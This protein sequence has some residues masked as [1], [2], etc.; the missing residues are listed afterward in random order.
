MVPWCRDPGAAA[1]ARSPHHHP[2]EAAE[3]ARH[4][5]ALSFS[6]PQ[7]LTR[8]PRQ[9][10]AAHLVGS[11]R[12][13]VH[14]IPPPSCL[15]LCRNSRSLSPF[16]VCFARRSQARLYAVRGADRRL[17]GLRPRPRVRISSPP[18][19]PP[20]PH[21]VVPDMHP[22]ARATPACS[23]SPTR[24]YSYWGILARM[25]IARYSTKVEC[26][27]CARQLQGG[28]DAAFTPAD[29]HDRRRAA[30]AK[31]HLVVGFTDWSANQ[32]CCC[33]VE[34]SHTPCHAGR[35]GEG[36]PQEAHHEARTRRH[37]AVCALCC[38]RAH[39][40]YTDDYYCRTWSNFPA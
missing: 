27:R 21:T 18:S 29:E 33:C 7:P 24:A 17:L 19:L 26:S 10:H 13:L 38:A 2:D 9:L 30:S 25:G 20:P 36:G 16:F 28:R 14:P 11:A 39:T 12:P 8:L 5:C 22:A 4:A 3:R 40:Q 15:P 37:P 34:S 1:G 23:L 35:A 6:P 32:N 31:Q